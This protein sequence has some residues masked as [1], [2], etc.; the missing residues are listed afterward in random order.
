MPP[1]ATKPCHSSLPLGKQRPLSGQSLLW[2][3]RAEAICSSWLLTVK[4]PSLFLAT[5]FSGLCHAQPARLILRFEFSAWSC[6][7]WK[8]QELS[9]P[10][11]CLW[12]SISVLNVGFDARSMAFKANH[13]L[14]IL[15]WLRHFL[16]VLTVFF[17]LLLLPW[18]CSSIA[19]SRSKG[20]RNTNGQTITQVVKG[21]QC[22]H[23]NY[24]FIQR[25]NRKGTHP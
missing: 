17:Y 7:S 24:H 3:C 4:W 11:K 15:I 18:V 13:K 16:T 19:K 9:H 5:F 25:W 2:S 21:R 8:G 12:Q 10:L 23:M 6:P 14:M 22:S 20:L 1:C